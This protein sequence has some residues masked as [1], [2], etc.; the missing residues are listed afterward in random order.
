M[1][2][3]EVLYKLSARILRKHI[4][5]IKVQRSEA[6]LK[7]VKHG[8]FVHLFSGAIDNKKLLFHKQAV[9]N[10]GFCTTRTQELGESGQ[11]MYE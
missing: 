10:S 7:F 11:Q 2:E 3:Q 9:S 8:K 4:I 1:S 5:R 6:R